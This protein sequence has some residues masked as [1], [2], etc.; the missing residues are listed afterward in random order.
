MV[1]LE[2]YP[3]FIA[4]CS[5]QFHELQGNLVL[6][7][8]KN[9]FKYKNEEAASW[10]VNV[11][12]SK[13]AENIIDLSIVVVNEARK[14]NRII[15]DG[16]TINCTI[17]EDGMERSHEFRCPEINSKELLLVDMFLKLSRNLIKE[18]IFINYIELL[19]GYFN[20]YL[21]VK[22]FDET[23]VRLRIYGS[24]SIHEKAGLEKVI[25]NI[26]SY[27]SLLIDMRNFESMG[28]ILYESFSPLKKIKDL[29]FI[30]N[31]NAAKQLKEME[32]DELKITIVP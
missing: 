10:Q 1:K 23:P 3:A 25:N 12:D 20:G 19:E 4:S 31:E 21:P 2:I 6:S 17:T 26:S 8:C 15:L 14:D 13:S 27:E 28:T 18:P 29:R 22:L 5:L 11:H 32:F 16:V 7:F 24:L 30:A 9:R